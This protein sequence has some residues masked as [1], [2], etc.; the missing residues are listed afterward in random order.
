[1]NR[2]AL[3][4]RLRMHEGLR[5]AVYDDA[6]GLKVTKGSTLVGHPTIG[7]GR[8][9]SM[10][11]ISEDEAIIL[12]GNDIVEV[13]KGLDALCTRWRGLDETRQ[14]VLAEMCFNVGLGGTVRKF[15]FGAMMMKEGTSHGYREGCVG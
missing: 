1:M 5:L 10:H 7:I 14:Q 12:C 3:I 9:L 15:V 4:A 8:E 13:E 11:G 2:D 6:T